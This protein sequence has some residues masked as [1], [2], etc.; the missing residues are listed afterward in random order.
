MKEFSRSNL[1][2]RIFIC[3]SHKDSQAVRD[4]YNRLR[5]DGFDPWFE[6]EN[7]PT[8]ENQETQISTALKSNKL[9][10]SNFIIFCLSRNSVG[11]RGQLP[12]DLKSI[13]ASVNGLPS[14]TTSVIP[15]KLNECDIPK[16]LNGWNWINL[17][18]RRGYRKLKRALQ[19]L[20]HTHQPNHRMVETQEVSAR[21]DPLGRYAYPPVIFMATTRN[22]GDTLKGPLGKAAGEEL[23]ASMDDEPF[24]KT[25]MF[26]PDRRWLSMYGEGAMRKVRSLVEEVDGVPSNW[27]GVMAIGAD[28]FRIENGL[29]DPDVLRRR[30]KRAALL[31]D[32][33]VIYDLLPSLPMINDSTLV[34][35]LTWLWENEIICQP[36]VDDEKHLGL[37]D[38]YLSTQ[39]TVN[40]KHARA[41]L[42]VIDTV[43]TFNET[44]TKETRE[45]CFQVTAEAMESSMWWQVR[46]VSFWCREV[47][48]ARV[49]PIVE[50]SPPEV[51]RPRPEI[52]KRL[53]TALKNGVRRKID[54]GLGSKS[55]DVIQIILKALPLPGDETSWQDLMEYR[56]DAESR[57]AVSALRNW[58]NET[59]RLALPSAEISDKLTW[60]MEQY[61]A[62]VEQ[63]R[64]KFQM[65]WA[66]LIL[67]TTATAA[68][69]L[70][71]LRPGS[72]A[73]ELFGLKRNKL[74]L[75]QAELK[76]P[77]SEVAYILK[78]GQHFAR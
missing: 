78:A 33:I 36:E 52:S 20:S 46:N 43:N 23:Q 47:E 73:K 37:S 58:A 67:T 65:G 25:N 71:H 4:L 45:A 32:R 38:D 57:Y 6:G 68:E 75:T 8:G 9:K 53:Q 35:E 42:A 31:F 59:A 44:P 60:L 2:P 12:A 48:D 7:L 62:H 30:L 1:Q 19:S 27:I 51:L 28:A 14:E 49:I 3:N 11:K 50:S 15:L 54:S 29:L 5:A 70:I 61:R 63:H 34:G 13:L 76:A 72:A 41:L 40:H 66:E 18:E 24:L 26:V 69:E 39:E 22:L 74:E 21:A 77:G 56:S 55:G 17:F 10:D 16:R 64:L